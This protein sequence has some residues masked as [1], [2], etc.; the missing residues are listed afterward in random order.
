MPRSCSRASCYAVTMTRRLEA[1]GSEKYR[2][3][4][5]RGK[6]HFNGVVRI[7]PDELEAP[8]TWKKP[9]RVFVNSM[10]DLFHPGVPDD[11]ILQVFSVMSRA[12]QH[13]FQILTKR[14][15]RARE[16]SPILDWPGNVWMGTSVED[17]HVIERIDELRA[18]SAAI[19]FLSLEP[20]IGP[21]PGLELTGID[22]VIVGGES[23]PNAR[24]ME[25][26]WV[27]HIRDVCA[28]AGVPFFFKQ[29]GGRNKKAAGRILDGRTH[30]AYPAE[31]A[32]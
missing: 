21:L 26:G 10:S 15:E 20:L 4:V 18:T 31:L 19:K 9:R 7:H 14:P 5:N 12:E 23:G 13:H 3:L 28:D 22:W 6:S 11:F 30:D 8:L 1:M 17:M 16:L 27:R 25:A 24:P 32:A 29:W 2:G